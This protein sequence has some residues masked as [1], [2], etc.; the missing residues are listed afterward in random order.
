MTQY[1]MYLDEY[2]GETEYGFSLHVD[3]SNPLTEIEFAAAVR[4]VPDD[5]WGASDED[6]A[7]HLAQFTAAFI[8]MQIYPY[9]GTPAGLLHCD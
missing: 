8:R 9:T 7:W 3:S 6:N 5:G 1:Q 4:I 2:T